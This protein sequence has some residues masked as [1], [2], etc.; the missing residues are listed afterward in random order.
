MEKNGSTGAFKMISVFQY[1]ELIRNLVFKDLKLKYRD[2]TFGFLWS[3]A[4]PL[5]VIMVYS[6]V[7]GHLI[8]VGVE[9]FT[10]FLMIGILPWN[11]FAQSLMMSTGSILDNS[12]LIRKVAVPMEVFPVATVLFNLAQYILALI[13]LFPMAFVFFGELPSWSWLAFFPILLLHMIFTLGACFVVA[14][15][16][17]F[18]RDVRHFTEILLMLLFWLTPIIYDIGS[19]TPSLQSVIYLNPVSF[20]TLA[21]QKALYHN[22]YPSFAEAGTLAGL[23]VAMLVLGYTF[24]VRLK[25]RFAEEV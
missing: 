3:L 9:R 13:V 2:S 25:N 19:I 16:T 12:N 21:Y 6:F 18:Y 4:N 24:F 20:F 15:A 5:L 23:A 10:Y 14:T 11:F 22:V 7:F 8:R 1:R 17:V